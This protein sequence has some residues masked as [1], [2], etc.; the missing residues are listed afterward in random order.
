MLEDSTFSHVVVSRG[1]IHPI[2]TLDHRLDVRV[3]RAHLGGLD[4]GISDIPDVLL[5]KGLALFDV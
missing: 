2:R 1:Y 5:E 4:Q 3:V